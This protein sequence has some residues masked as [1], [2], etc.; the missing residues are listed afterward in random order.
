[1]RDRHS[2]APQRDVRRNHGARGEQ[3][4]R[5]SLAKATGIE[6]RDDVGHHGF[7]GRLAQLALDQRGHLGA[8]L[9]E[10]ASESR[11]DPAALA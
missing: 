7:S 4:S 2:L 3:A 5:A 1:V 9:E 10:A 11:Q 6:R 8:V